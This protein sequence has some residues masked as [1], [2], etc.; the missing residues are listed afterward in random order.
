MMLEPLGVVRRLTMAPRPR[1]FRSR[2]PRLVGVA[3]IVSLLVV[4]VLAAGCVSRVPPRPPERPPPEEIARSFDEAVVAYR[5]ASEAG[6]TEEACRAVA[7]HFVEVSRRDPAGVPAALFNAGLAWSHCGRHDEARR[8]FEEA[9]EAEQ[10]LCECPGHAPSLLRLG[11]AAYRSG[12]R[13][14]AKQLFDRAREADRASADAYAN[15][16]LLQ[17]EEG[18]YV[19]AQRELRRA[20]AV[21]SDHLVAYSQ[22]ALL[23]LDLAQKNRQML[24]IA[25][26]VCQQ[27]TARAR[28]VKAAPLRVAPIHNAW[29]LARLGRGD[30]VGATEQFDRARSLDPSLFEAHMNFGAVNLSFRGYEAAEGAFRTALKLR[31]RSYEAQLSLGAA[32]RGLRQLE[33]AR[34]AYDAA[35]GLDPAR[36][37]AYYNL[38]VLSQ[39]YLLGEAAGMEAQIDV[40]GQAKA[41]YRRFL[42]ACQVRPDHCLRPGADGEERDMRGAA[43]R[44][45]KACDETAAGLREALGAT[46]AVTPRK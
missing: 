30:V 40:L 36:P 4:A 5:G 19:G 43:R 46:A 15:L 10:R 22:M 27:A 6:W 21:D 25:E 11:A 33:E 14:R 31:P 45:I 41:D 39:D 29:G 1:S 24:D 28:H 20:L 7:E 8:L 17:R 35:K 44:R 32:L 3:G 2:K 13:R 12:D 34:R 16:G 37:E 42:E 23:Y 18:D 38:G 9:N 26:L